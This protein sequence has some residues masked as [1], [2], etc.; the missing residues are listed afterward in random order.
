MD[1][2]LI[3]LNY[4]VLTKAYLSL[5]S[6]I[7]VLR[8]DKRQFLLDELDNLGSETHKIEVIKINSSNSFTL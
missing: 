2:I 8:T 1:F 5:F 6:S 4:V 7:A 3:G